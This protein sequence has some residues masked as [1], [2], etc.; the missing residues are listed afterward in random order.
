MS[1]DWV[2]DASGNKIQLSETNHASETGDSKGSAS[3]VTILSYLF[4]GPLGLFAHNFV[5]GR[6]VTIGPDK[7]FTV[8][9]DH[10][11]NMHVTQRALDPGQGFEH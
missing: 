5:H 10:D 11:V 1:I 3:T 4:L 7:T 6:D 8:F 9:V 2:Y